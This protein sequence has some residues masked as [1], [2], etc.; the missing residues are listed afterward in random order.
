MLDDITISKAILKRGLEKLLK[1]TDSEVVIAVGGPSGLSASYFLAKEGIKVTVFERALKTGGG[2]PGGGIGLP[3]IVIQEEGLEI[4]EEFGISY[5][6]FEE[7]GY[8]TADSLESSAKLVAGAIDA[9]VRIINLITVEDVMVNDNKLCG[10]VINRTP[11]V[12]ASLHVDP[13]SVRANYVI[14]ATGHDT[15]VVKALLKRKDI[16]LN[17]PSGGIEGEGP[18]WALKGEESII[19]NTR[20]VFPNLYITGMAANAVYGS[21]RMGPIFGGMLQSGKKAAELIKERL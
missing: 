17:T 15:E 3:I 12:M 1:A 7:K 8:Y 11:I 21:P 20:E 2:M 16:K 18:M 5:K 4:L 14:D 9:G 6:V 10:V 19:S 13:I